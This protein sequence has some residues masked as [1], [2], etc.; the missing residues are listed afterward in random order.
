MVTITSLNDY[1]AIVCDPED[2]SDSQH[3]Y[4]DYTF[5]Y[6]EDEL[7]DALA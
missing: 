1:L 5:G 2:S 7:E 4:E 3:E 6:S